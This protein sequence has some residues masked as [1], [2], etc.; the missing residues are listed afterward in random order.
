MAFLPS[1]SSLS[2][3]LVLGLRHGLDPDHVAVIDNVTFRLARDRS[4][5]APWVGALFASGHSLSVTAV[6][7]CVSLAAIRLP[8]PAWVGETVD[9]L[10]IGLLLLVGVANLGALLKAGDYVPMGWRQGLAPRRLLATGHPVGILAI[11]VIF[12]L[13]FDTASQVAAWSLAASS[14]A[15]PVGVAAITVMFAFGMIITDSLDSLIVSRLLRAGGDPRRVRRYRRG[16]GW[17]I[18][19]L[20]F[21]M[22][23]FA[24]A[25]KLL[26]P[27]ETSEAVTLATGGLMAAGVIVALV[28]GRLLRPSRSARASC[29]SGRVS[30]PSN[31]RR[32]S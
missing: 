31:R 22:A 1:P 14:K 11:G 30:L 2:L 10:I 26:K 19:G 5:V 32:D 25:E 24:L 21:G 16:V 3:G 6:A 23:G 18:V 28:F 17:L 8:F 13:M 4:P 9:W 12:G 27:G 7:L 20:S 29:R 15:G